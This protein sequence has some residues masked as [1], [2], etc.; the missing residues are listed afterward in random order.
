VIVVGTI[1]VLALFLLFGWIIF[2]EMLQHRVW[3]RRVAS[4]DLGIVVAL[5]EEAL[6]AWR[7]AR[8]PKEMPSSLWAAVQGA[9]LVAVAPGMATVSTSA[10][11]EFRT[12]GGAR[13][14]VQ[15][16]LDE[17]I[18]IAAKLVDMMLYDV[19]NLRLD[20]VRVDVYATFTGPDGTPGQRP[21]LTTTAARQVADHLAWEELSPAEVLARFETHFDRG[22]SGQGLAIELPPVEG[23]APA[24]FAQQGAS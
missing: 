3:R 17:A 19:P 7:R 8:P 12:E 15:S 22:P 20:V 9:Q 5:I 24:E 23:Q 16:A 21:I 11:P 4:G 13:V 14:Q 2:T 1:V 18:A 10:E 6:G